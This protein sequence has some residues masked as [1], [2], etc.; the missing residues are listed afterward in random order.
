MLKFAIAI[1]F[2]I[3]TLG[4]QC[5]TNNDVVTS[6]NLL[7]TYQGNVYSIK[8]Y[9]HPGGK[10]IQETIGKDLGQFLNDPRYMFHKTSSKFQSALSTLYVGVLQSVCILPTTNTPIIPVTDTTTNTPIIPV[11]DTTT[12]PAI[13]PV[14]DTNTNAPIIP[15]INSSNRI[16]LNVYFIF[17]FLSAICFIN[18]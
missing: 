17:S 13:V 12:N 9:N 11:T 18:I 6:P 16:E 4:Q 5:F 1:N 10:I 7:F 15:E 14:T 2:L 8:N 3:L